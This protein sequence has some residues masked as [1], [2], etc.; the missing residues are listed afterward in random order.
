MEQNSFVFKLSLDLI[1]ATISLVFIL[2]WD[3]VV[4]YIRQKA[5]SNPQIIY[6][7]YLRN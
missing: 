2:P 5:K 7:W 3:Q 1:C 4:L 6:Y